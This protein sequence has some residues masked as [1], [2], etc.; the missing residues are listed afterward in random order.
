[1]A[2]LGIDLGTTNSIGVVFRN[3][4][5]EMIPNKWNTY[6]TPSVV[7]KEED[8]I[9]V[10][11]DAKRM[12]SVSGSKISSFK[13][14]MGVKE[15]VK[16]GTEKIS[17]EELSAHIVQSIIEDAKEYLQENIEEVV[18]S[19]PAYFN[20]DE[21]ISTKKISEYINI[22]VERLI[23]EP[24]A[25]S[26]HFHDNSKEMAY[27]VCDLGGGTLDVSVVDCF[28]DVVSICSIAGDMQLGGI[29]FDALIK[30]YVLKE[31]KI[32][33]ITPN[34]SQKLLE[35]CEAKK[36]ELQ[37]KEEVPITF[38]IRNKE[39]TI[40]FSNKI[41]YRLSMPLFDKITGT[42][43]NAVKSS[44]FKK[45]DLSCVILV[46]GS[47]NMPIL[48]EFLKQL[49]D[50][51]ILIEGNLDTV[52]A[53]GLGKYI[54]IKTRQEEVRDIV[55]TDICPF[56][57]GVG[58]HNARE[59]NKLLTSIIIPRNSV[60]PI[61]RKETYVTVWP[62]QPSINFKVSQGE[63]KYL[64]NNI[65]LG[66]IEI[67][68][69]INR[70][71]REQVDITYTYDINSI[72]FI[73]MKVLS[74]GEKKLYKCLGRGVMKEV[75]EED[76][77]NI[78]Q[79]KDTI[80]KFHYENEIDEVMR[81]YQYL[82]THLSEEQTQA[83]EETMESFKVKL[84]KLDNNLRKKENAIKEVADMLS[85]L[86]NATLNIDIFKTYVEELDDTEEDNWDNN[87]KDTFH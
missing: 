19:V 57:L 72:L 73:E 79:I 55:L 24:S 31:A 26:L 6:L 46:G 64:E 59:V 1:M 71:S 14:F 78:H 8:K 42:I 10:G 23:N 33:T 30:D 27:V 62:G 47:C 36:K 84:M 28:E 74:T 76:Y 77:T 16:M 18:I 20:M 13:R 58:V 40:P 83:L 2:V 86:M 61:H 3:G 12:E 80:H 49:L 81:K 9:F 29:D 22:P 68:V 50:I 53:Q 38:T 85:K 82:C 66:E 21:R 67:D 45:K 52:V 15:Y 44:G 56:S 41:F 25:A 51:D 32:H 87:E 54:G 17:P 75:I 39:Y 63:S 70:V 37:N 35:I 7:F 5:V 34:E 65:T 69:P 43:A 11:E 48:Q 60:L 4:Q